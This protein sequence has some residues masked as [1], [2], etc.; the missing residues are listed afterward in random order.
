MIWHRL[1]EHRQRPLTH[2]RSKLLRNLSD[3]Y[4]QCFKSAKPAEFSPGVN[5][6]EEP[7]FLPRGVPVPR[8]WEAVGGPPFCFA[9]SASIVSGCALMVW[10]VALVSTTLPARGGQAAP[11]T[12]FVSMARRS[13]PS[14]TTIR[15]VGWKR[16]CAKSPM[17]PCPASRNPWCSWARPAPAGTICCTPSLG[18]VDS[19]I[20]HSHSLWAQ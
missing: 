2:L 12:S 9:A 11:S 1:R 5:N 16:G 7:P 13:R 19:T 15:S 18:W 8:N 20:T 17:A 10:T 4:W 6:P 14:S 3:P